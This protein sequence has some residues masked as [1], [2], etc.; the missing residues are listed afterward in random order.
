VKSKNLKNKWLDAM[1][2]NVN[3]VNKLLDMYFAVLSDVSFDEAGRGW[4]GR[5]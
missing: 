4:A 2:R 3:S 5:L 1:K